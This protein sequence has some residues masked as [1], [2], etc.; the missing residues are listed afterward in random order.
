MIDKFYCGTL[1]FVNDNWRFDANDKSAELK[2][3]ADFFGDYLTA[4]YE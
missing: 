1:R 2:Q 3:L 4:W